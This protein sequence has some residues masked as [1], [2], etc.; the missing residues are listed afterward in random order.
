MVPFKSNARVVQTCLFALVV[1]ALSFSF[2]TASAEIKLT[3][4]LSIS[5]FLKLSSVITDDGD[6][7]TASLSFDQF[8]LD[9]H[10]NSGSVTARVDIDSTGNFSHP[11]EDIGQS[12]DVVLEQGFVTYTFSKDVLPG[13]SITAG[14]FLS[15]LGFE[16]AEPDGLYQF[17]VSEGIPYPGYQNGVAV[18]LKPNDKFGLYAAVLSGV[19]DVSDTNLEDP[20]FEA[21]LSLMPIEQVTAKVGFAIDDTGEDD[22][23]S[24]LNA[25]VSFSQGLL[26]LAGEID[27]LN[28][29]PSPSEEGVVRDDGIH[30]LGMVNLSLEDVLSAPLALTVRF[31]GI[32]LKDEEISKEITVSPS[33]SATDNWLLLAEFK[34][35][36]DK[37]ET[38]FAVESLFTF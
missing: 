22:K 13:A 21:Q 38:I 16:A 11:A 2:S 37:D 35:R 18:S 20:G 17:S 25:W 33:F 12:Q 14:R 5:G 19:W 8:E 3:D 23:R 32:D 34:R 27:I 26:T 28:N 29:W 7:K 15:S 9:F 24:E 1:L 6:D 36:I 30:F 31:S 4:N 10:F